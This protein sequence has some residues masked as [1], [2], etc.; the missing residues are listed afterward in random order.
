MAL[1]PKGSIIRQV[2]YLV[3]HYNPE[4]YWRMRRE[5]V[6]PESK[7][8]LI[9]RIIYLYRIK[10]MDAF[11]NASMGTNL[12]SGAVF[13]SPPRLMHG[14]NGQ[15][16]SH[17]ARFGRDCLIHQQ[18]TVAQSED[19]RAANI[20]DNCYIGAGARIIGDVTIGNNVKIGANAVVVCDVPDNST[21]VG[22]PARIIRHDNSRIS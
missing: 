6:D 13:A 8:P 7:I 12:G 14:L 22:V 4:S 11:N 19:N 15:V 20:G 3:Q 17:Y 1:N 16:I 2:R 5:V 10:R 9:L 18:V 21:A